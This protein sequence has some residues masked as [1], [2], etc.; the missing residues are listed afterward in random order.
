MH[1]NPMV[2]C[3]LV[4]DGAV[5]GEGWHEQY[6]GPHA[7]RVALGRAGASARG[8]TAYVSL[9]PCAHHGKTPPCTDAL[10]DAG[11][12]RVVYGVADP[13]RVAAGGAHRLAEAGVDVVGPV[14]GPDRGRQENPLFFHAR[15]AGGPFVALKLAMGLDGRL[16]ERSGAPSRVT[17]PEARAEA[18]RL[19]AGYDA[20]AVGIG[21]VLADDP[22]LTVREGPVH[23][24]VPPARVVLD[25]ALRVPATARLLADVAT[26]PLHVFA[27]ADAAPEAEARLTERGV[28]VHRVPR[29]AS[30]ALQL[31]AVL[32][33]C[34]R[35]GLTSVF[36]EGGGRLG[37]S[38]L[39]EGRVDRL[40]LFLAP[41]FLGPLGTPAFGEA[42]TPSGWRP[43]EEPR[44]LG[45]DLLLTLEPER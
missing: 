24:R 25:S 34:G 5:V 39:A 17:G 6:G 33:T 11:V 8:S 4:R 26:L 38:L 12:A 31:G 19:R 29:G 2:G 41:R 30:G 9:E 1:P 45:R 40:H 15:E 14:F 37:T 36:F 21:T 35:L 23:P 7:E 28:S 16:S 42:L 20:V 43:V 13:D 22:L 18:H 3:V 32:D 10:I 44:T 27:A